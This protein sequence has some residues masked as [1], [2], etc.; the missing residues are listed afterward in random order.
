MRR[1]KSSKMY[2]KSADAINKSL[3]NIQNEIHA[4]TLFEY[5]RST[6]FLFLG[7][8]AN[9]FTVDKQFRPKIMSI[10]NELCEHK[11]NYCRT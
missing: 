8:H 11:L 10:M 1:Y 5:D 6:E 4:F 7:S 2:L 3:N 9:P